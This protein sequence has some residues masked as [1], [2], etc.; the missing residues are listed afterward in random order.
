MKI[1]LKR[2]V[3]DYPKGTEFFVLGVNWNE[4]GKF[5]YYAQNSDK[6]TVIEQEDAEICQ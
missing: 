6:R 2:A 4:S 1:K 5:K 3:G